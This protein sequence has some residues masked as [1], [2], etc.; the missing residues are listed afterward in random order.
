MSDYR[1]SRQGMGRLCFVSATL[2]L[3]SCGDFQRW[4]NTLRDGDCWSLH[5]RMYMSGFLKKQQTMELRMCG[6]WM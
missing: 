4:T 6:H 3:F 2:T 5:R 1:S